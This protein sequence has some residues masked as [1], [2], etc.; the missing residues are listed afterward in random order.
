MNKYEIW[1]EGFLINGGSGRACFYG[2][3]EGKN[4]KEACIR[5]FKDH[6]TFDKDRLTLWGC[7]IFDNEADA[8]R[9]FWLILYK[10]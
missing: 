9:N 4:F 8:R 3:H 2:I 10:L 5:C 6:T 1:V 7:R